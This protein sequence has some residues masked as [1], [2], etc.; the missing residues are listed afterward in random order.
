MEIAIQNSKELY[1]YFMRLSRNNTLNPNGKQH[2]LEV[3]VTGKIRKEIMCSV[4]QSKIVL[5]GRVKKI[6][7]DNLGG[8]VYKAYLEDL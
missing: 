6:K 4:E 2:K 5:D 7:F 1:D 8:G 3:F